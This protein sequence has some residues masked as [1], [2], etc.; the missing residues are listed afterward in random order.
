MR[1]RQ[2]LEHTPADRPL[3]TANHAK[4]GLSL[5]AALLAGRIAAG[6][7]DHVEA[8]AKLEQAVKLQDALVYDEPPDWYYPSRESLRFGIAHNRKPEAKRRPSTA[9]I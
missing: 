8:E 5:A 4:D 7:G 9:R 2:I 3:G 1:S 6:R